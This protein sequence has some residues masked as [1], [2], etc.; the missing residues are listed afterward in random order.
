MFR[1][2]A[3]FT[4]MT[5]LWSIFSVALLLL[6]L[7]IVAAAQCLVAVAQTPIPGISTKPYVVTSSQAFPSLPLSSKSLVF[8]NGLL[9]TAGIDYDVLPGPGS[10]RFRPGVLD[11]GDRV[12][13]VTLP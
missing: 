2:I 12:A 13:V 1:K 4:G 7:C 9:Q 3:Y 5:M 10:F 6:F 11:D 8:R